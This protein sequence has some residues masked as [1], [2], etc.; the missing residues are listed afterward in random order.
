VGHTNTIQYSSNL[1][2]WFMLTNSV[3]SNA[4]W[5]VNDRAVT[6]QPRRFYRAVVA[7]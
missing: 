1:V 3:L 2:S 5:L 4:T 7:P 6:N